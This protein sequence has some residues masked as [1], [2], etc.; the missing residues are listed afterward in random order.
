[1][2]EKGLEGM[3]KHTESTKPRRGRLVSKFVVAALAAII[4]SSCSPSEP[5]ASA[6]PT[7]PPG[8]V[9][10]QTYADLGG[11]SQYL[12]IRGADADNPVI[13]WLHG[14]PGMPS[15]Y[16]TNTYQSRLEG[17]YTVIQWDQR[18]CGRT[19]IKTPDAPVSL[20]LLL[21]DLDDLVDYAAQRFHQPIYLVGHSWGSVLGSSYAA[22]H[23]DKLAGYVGIGQVVDF[24]QSDKLAAEAGEEVARQTGNTQDADE[25]ARRYQ[26]YAQN[27]IQD[28]DF[29]G[30]NFVT[31]RALETKYLSPNEKDATESAMTSPDFG[32]EDAQWLDIA[33]KD[34]ARWWAIEA[35]LLD[36]AEAFTPPSRL[37]VPVAFIQGGDDYVCSTTLT[38]EYA[39]TLAAP[40]PAV[41]HVMDGLGHFIMFDDPDAF[42]DTLLQA[43]AGLT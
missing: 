11:V 10:E 12:N 37:D 40:R 3:S 17:S 21:G 27:G 7:G 41:V 15:S 42:A 5:S 39:K 2:D 33:Q 16:V 29:D 18:G 38:Q 26:A 24:R 35:P 13:I 4:V 28:P 43:L 19:Y 31:M 23:P 8:G 20:D 6:A 14:G 9:R 22:A 1:L 32:P 36:A 34:L 30:M 25:I